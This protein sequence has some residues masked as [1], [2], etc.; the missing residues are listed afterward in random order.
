MSKYTTAPYGL[1]H[2]DHSD[3]ETLVRLAVSEYLPVLRDFDAMGGLSRLTIQAGYSLTLQ[4][5]E[6]NL[7]QIESRL[8]DLDT[9]EID[10]TTFR[11]SVI[12]EVADA[13][14]RYRGKLPYNAVPTMCQAMRH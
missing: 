9:M 11:R 13:V 2:T 6:I 12:E 4:G 5:I 14:T 10:P 8:F 3:T 7:G 1:A